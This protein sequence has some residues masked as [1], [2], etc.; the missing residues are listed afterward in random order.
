M[1]KTGLSVVLY[2]GFAAF[3]WAAEDDTQLAARGFS[4]E[5]AYAVGDLDNV[6]LHNGNLTLTVPIGISYPLGMPPDNGGLLLQLRLVYN[7]LVWDLEE[8]ASQIIE[9]IPVPS[10]ISNSGLGW[11]FTLGMLFPPGSELPN[12]ENRWLYVSPDGGKHYF[13]D[14]LHDGD[15]DG[16]AYT[17]Y[18][19]DNSYLRMTYLP[20]D[21]RKI[22][23]PDGTISLFHD[24]DPSA[25]EDWRLVSVSDR[26]GN[27]L[28]VS[29]PDAF[30]WHLD[31][32]EG[33]HQEVHFAADAELG[34][35]V[36]S[37][38]LTAFGGTTAVYGFNYEWRPVERCYHNSW[39]PG[40]PP[41]YLPLLADVDLPDGS[42]YAMRSGGEPAYLLDCGTPGGEDGIAGGITGLTLPTL[43]RL[44]WDYGGYWLPAIRSINREQVSGVTERRTLD[45]SG[46]VLGTWRYSNELIFEEPDPGPPQEPMIALETR[47]YVEQPDGSCTKHHFDG[48]ADEERF[49]LPR[50]TVAPGLVIGAYLFRRSVEL[51]T[52]TTEQPGA[53]F[54]PDFICSGQHL[55]TNYVA[56][57]WDP[58]GTQ[59]MDR[60]NRNRRVAWSAVVYEDDGD[61]WTRVIHEDFDGLGHHRYSDGDG[62]TDF[63]GG[64]Q[65]RIEYNP[66]RGTWGQ[67]FEMLPASEPWVIET[68]TKRTRDDS[69]APWHEQRLCFDAAG[70][71][72][73]VR[74]LDGSGAAP[75][76]T[77]HDPIMTIERDNALRRVTRRYYGGQV[78]PVMPVDG[79]LCPDLSG[80][81]PQY[82]R[83]E[84]FESGTLARS[85]WLQA[86]GAPY[87]F[88]FV[89]RDIDPSTGLVAFSRDTAGVG[90]SFTYDALGRL[91]LFLPGAGEG[92]STDYA[93]L[94]AQSGA[95]AAVVIE[96]RTNPGDA[97][98]T[99]ERL[100]FD[101]LGRL[102]RELRRLPETHDAVRETLYD[103]SGRRQS[104]SEWG[105]DAPAVNATQYSYDALG[106]PVQI[107]GADG[108]LQS[109]AY[110]GGRLVRPTT[111]VATSAGGEQLVTPYERY[112]G[113]GRLVEVSESSEGSAD[114]SQNP[115]QGPCARWFYDYGAADR[116]EFVWTNEAAH[117]LEY[118]YNSSGTLWFRQGPEENQRVALYGKYDA[119][120]HPGFVEGFCNGTNNT[121]CT[122][123]GWGYGRNLV[124]DRAGRV[125]EVWE[126]VGPDSNPQGRLIKRLVYADDNAAGDLRRGKLLSAARYNY[127]H[128]TGATTEFQHVHEYKAPGGRLS[129]R[130][131]Y[132][133]GVQQFGED[134]TWTELG[135][136]DTVRYPPCLTCPAA[137]DPE[138]IVDYEYEW[139]RL[140]AVLQESSPT[141]YASAIAYHPSGLLARIEHGNGVD[142]VWDADPDGM[143]RPGEIRTE[144]QFG[145]P[146]STG[147][148]AYD[149]SGN[150]KAMGSDAFTYDYVHRLKS[151]TLAG[152]TQSYTYDEFG[153]LKSIT[154]NGVPLTIGVQAQTNR[155]SSG[156]Y[157]R[158]G[159]LTRLGIT[160]FDYDF[161]SMATRSYDIQAGC[162]NP[163]RVDYYLY[164][165]DDER[166]ATDSWVPGLPGPDGCRPL[167]HFGW[168]WRT[169]NLDG[170]VLR[171]YFSPDLATWSWM[172]DWIHR[173]GQLLA[174]V[175]D[176]G[177]LRHF[178]LDHLGTPRMITGNGGEIRERHDYFP[179]G[180]EISTP[181]YEVMKFTG[182]EREEQHVNGKDLDYM[183]AR[184]MAPYV[185]R[186]L[187]ADP[188]SALPAVRL[189]QSLNRF[190][191]ALDNPLKLLDPNGR[192][193]LKFT[194]VTLIQAAETRALAFLPTFAGDAVPLSANPASYRTL[195]E[196][197][198]ES[199][200]GKGPALVASPFFD[201]GTT[202][203]LETGRE[204]E[205][206]TGGFFATAFRAGGGKT[207]VLLGASVDNP[208][209][210]SPNIDYQAAVLLD[211]T[212]SFVGFMSHDTFPSYGLYVTD[213]AGQITPLYE[214]DEAGAIQG[215][216]DLFPLLGGAVGGF[217]CGF[218]V[219][220]D[221]S[222]NRALVCSPSR[223]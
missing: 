195:A 216:L 64:R 79:N 204:A 75:N 196:V 78:Q 125:T 20:P 160:Y 207:V 35:I 70:L 108:A 134:Y 150:I 213:E 43:G 41:L 212:G 37:V 105:L 13:Y 67:N 45:A 87:N 30:T 92:A 174:V 22:E 116:L 194:A 73:Q 34:A 159:N 121:D 211:S 82:E 145:G 12:P 103:S 54:E 31:D 120:D 156:T 147:T 57:G 158:R 141:V 11:T 72:T 170:K 154:T 52:D 210:L 59:G 6:N 138:R 100:E 135:D 74:T 83:V 115:T 182:H 113:L 184:Y 151:A 191:Y 24:L 201:P 36:E 220:S 26:F 40:A 50:S 102:W 17:G 157:D 185:G 62:P 44:E 129:T 51:W 179:F 164:T 133:G 140:S 218:S 5:K 110:V 61:R 106:R 4:P 91:T 119:L 178:H 42:S 217:G 60:Y 209:A 223:Q 214:Y 32:S 16:S 131:T 124:R 118:R 189:P 219:G 2:L 208:L 139:G 49:G 27:Y 199:D 126:R 56:H 146:F 190:T 168:T 94:E 171:E 137:G 58:G 101:D 152:G 172:K 167:L 77:A 130:W 117:D 112:D 205:A 162:Q 148:F 123:A 122:A 14:E 39:D 68:Y 132:V 222:G 202:R 176:G 136:L 203:N 86:G 206:G 215:P 33:R 153:N 193:N 104:V 192:E 48:P 10:A 7:S 128:V 142:T 85:Y 187:T 63:F 1:H 188:S 19:R 65:T 144:G 88:K 90:T 175:S 25:G 66:E 89:D 200:P 23:A 71:V 143:G 80:L 28:G 149:G 8:H 76:V 18:T 93:Y 173:E 183:H 166:I 29:Y 69:N 53:L 109:V 38:E 155:L 197:T 98:L 114:C 221:S 84:E 186:F 163:E 99:R 198:V 95:R 3:T 169:R 9:T 21:G 97:V 55:R 111:S 46:N 165:A 81:T 177:E 161:M 127:H 107:T 15:N 47:T 180:E 181:Y 96:R